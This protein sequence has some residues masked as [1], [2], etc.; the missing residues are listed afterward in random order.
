MWVSAHTCIIT[1]EENSMDMPT[2]TSHLHLY[3][4]AG[5]SER[6]KGALNS[7]THKHGSPMADSLQ[8]GILR[9]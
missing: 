8:A 1:F 6:G 5:D 4:S 2:A 9:A 7:S 3:N